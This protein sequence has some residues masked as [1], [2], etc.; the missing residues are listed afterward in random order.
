MKKT[1]LTAIAC[2]AF[3]LVACDNKINKESA[4]DNFNTGGTATIDTAARPAAYDTGSV[5]T[6]D[7]IPKR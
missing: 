3:A 6:P 7:S 2:A 5:P 1:I 4:P